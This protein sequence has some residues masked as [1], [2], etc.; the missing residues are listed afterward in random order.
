MSNIYGKIKEHFE[1]PIEDSRRFTIEI[2]IH[3]F[4]KP[5]SPRY[6]YSKCA[7]CGYEQSHKVHQ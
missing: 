3:K 1:Y 2:F 5:N 4:R 6:D 7:D